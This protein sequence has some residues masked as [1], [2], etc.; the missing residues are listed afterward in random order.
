V[1]DDHRRVPMPAERYDARW[2]AL[3]ASGQD[4]HGEA[5][6]VDALLGGPPARVLDA[7]CGTGRVA[8]ELDRR[9][10]DTVGL[11]V[12]ATLLERARVKAPTL[13]W[14]EADLASLPADLAPGPFAAAVLAGNVM[15]FVARGSEGAVLANLA[16]R[17]APGG[18]VVAGFQLS[19]RLPLA[20][21]D[22]AATAAG[23]ALRARWS[24]WDRAPFTEG[25]EYAVSVHELVSN[26]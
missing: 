5:A 19:G 14:Q 4:V 7:G 16:P 3:A 17:L 21:Y 11:D 24:T 1:D 6:L 15:I 10:Y 22:A 12:D 13:T 25:D 20:E 2:E 9:G 18:L 8:I 23:L 26:R